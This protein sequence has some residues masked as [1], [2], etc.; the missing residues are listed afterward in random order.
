M[1]VIKRYL[2]SIILLS[3]LGVVII[4]GAFQNNNIEKDI[5]KN[6]Y[7]VIAKIEKLVNKRS[8]RRVY[9][10]YDYKGVNFKST[11]L[12][13]SNANVLVDEYYQAEISNKNPSDSRINLNVKIANK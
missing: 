1:S 11:E 3:I 9:Y 7:F 5:D 4:I 8:L 13:D 12:I 2:F 10:S 6:S